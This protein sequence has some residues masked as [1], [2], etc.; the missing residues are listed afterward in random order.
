MCCLF[1][2][3][4]L[5]CERSDLYSVPSSFRDSIPFL[6]LLLILFLDFACV[7]CKHVISS[8]LW[9]VNWN[10]SF[11]FLCS[12]E[13]M[14]YCTI[15]RC[16]VGATRRIRTTLQVCCCDQVDQRSL[17]CPFNDCHPV[18]GLNLIKWMKRNGGAVEGVEVTVKRTW[19]RMDTND[20]F[21]HHAQQRV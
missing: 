15:V 12:F 19:Q 10:T 20:N 13:A 5:L 17:R 14:I 16:K 21:L 8:S 9:D 1:C 4:F 11:L 7:E 2:C 3:F 6:L 18:L